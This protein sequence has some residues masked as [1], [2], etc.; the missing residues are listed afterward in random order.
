MPAPERHVADATGKD[1]NCL[2]V[3][4]QP[5]VVS[6]PGDSIGYQRRVEESHGDCAL[7]ST[8]GD[9]A[10]TRV[11]DAGALGYGCIPKI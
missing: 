5:T 3:A 7:N 10:I 11:R 6:S 8:W 4:W 2:R 1:T 9:D